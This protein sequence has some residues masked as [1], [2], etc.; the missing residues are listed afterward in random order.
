MNLK[1]L[2]KVLSALF[3]VVSLFSACE[4]KTPVLTD[5]QKEEIYLF[6]NCTQD[7]MHGSVMGMNDGKNHTYS[8]AS[9]LSMLD[10]TEKGTHLLG[11]RAYIGDEVTNASVWAGEDYENPTTTKNL[12]M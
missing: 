2:F 5:E 9:L 3:L 8:A 1:N 11:V 10:L 12:L 7:G 4:P 6:G